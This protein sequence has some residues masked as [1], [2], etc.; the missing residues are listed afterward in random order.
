MSDQPVYPVPRIKEAHGNTV[1]SRYVSNVLTVEV[2]MWEGAE[3]RQR[4]YV[5]LYGRHGGSDHERRMIYSEI[6][7]RRDIDNGKLEISVPERVY[8]G[9][10]DQKAFSIGFGVGFN[11]GGEEEATKFTYFG[12]YMLVK[13]TY[14]DKTDFRADN[15]GGWVPG[16]DVNP[17]DLTFETVDGKRCL[18]YPVQ[19]DMRHRVIL[20]KDFNLVPGRRYFFNATFSAPGVKPQMGVVVYLREGNKVATASLYASHVFYSEGGGVTARSSTVRLAI[21][22]DNQGALVSRELNISDIA[23]YEFDSDRWWDPEW[24]LEWD[25]ESYPPA[26]DAESELLSV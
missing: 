15:L 14:N 12:S 26:K 21:V 1:F 23:L 13:D 16:P 17:A 6:L 8:G 2:D 10:M 22:A 9:L 19:S 20:Y 4:Y 25:S 24:D 11:G 5:W 7:T 3:V 18:H